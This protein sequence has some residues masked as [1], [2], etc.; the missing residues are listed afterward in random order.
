MITEMMEMEKDV[1]GEVQKQ[2]LI[3][4]GHTNRMDEMRWPRKVLEWVPQ[5]KRKQGQ[6]GWGWRD[7]IKTAME[8]RNLTEEDC[9]RRED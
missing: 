2:Q 1:I 6:L 5:E 4:C 9:Y 7:D 8:A 3:W